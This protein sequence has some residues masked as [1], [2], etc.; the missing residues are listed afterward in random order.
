VWS[1]D[2]I[3]SILVVSGI[4]III[5]YVLKEL[6]PNSGAG[7]WMAPA[8]KGHAPASSVGTSMAYAKNWLVPY[9]GFLA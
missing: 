6:M 7:I 4:G 1:F 5:A 9:H 2:L 8:L 3:G